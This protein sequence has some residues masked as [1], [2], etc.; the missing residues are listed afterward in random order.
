MKNAVW[1]L[2][3]V[4]AIAAYLIARHQE[5]IA[6]NQPVEVLAHKLEVAWADHHTVA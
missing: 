3:G 2:S 5:R 4:S 6:R 1:I